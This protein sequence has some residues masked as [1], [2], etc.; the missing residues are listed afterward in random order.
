M[1]SLEN[2][3]PDDRGPGCTPGMPGRRV[4]VDPFPT[5]ARGAHV[6]SRGEYVWAP[7]PYLLRGGDLVG[8]AGEVGNCR[9]G[10]RR[11]GS[12]RRRR[13]TEEQRRGG[14]WGRRPR[15]RRKGREGGRVQQTGRYRAVKE[16]KRRRRWGDARTPLTRAGNAHTRSLWPTH[17]RTAA[18]THTRAPTVSEA[19][20]PSPPSPPRPGAADPWVRRQTSTGTC[21][22]TSA[23]GDEIPRTPHPIPRPETSISAP[24]SRSPS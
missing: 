14:G 24:R 12:Q 10:N 2:Q 1:G 15:A 7:V 13:E 4:R 9:V 5:E 3:S 8:R 11:R 18:P 19:R 20:R 22:R 6:R 17:T 16:G 23:E 21:L